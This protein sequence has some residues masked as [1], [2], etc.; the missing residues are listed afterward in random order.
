MKHEYDHLRQAMFMDRNDLLRFRQ[1]I[2]NMVLATDIFDKELNDL[3]KK[4]W[5]KAFETSSGA[6]ND[7]VRATIVMEHII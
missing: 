3:Q 6:G 4:R 2:V 1:I 5:T 7:N